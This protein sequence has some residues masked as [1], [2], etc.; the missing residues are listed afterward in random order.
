MPAIQAPEPLPREGQISSG[1]IRDDYVAYEGLGFCIYS[2]I[3]ADKIQEPK[4]RKLWVKAR[5]AMQEVVG[6]LERAPAPTGVRRDFF[7]KRKAAKKKIAKVEKREAMV[8]DTSD[9]GID[10]LGREV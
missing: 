7:T 9:F 4:L 6:Y 10:S 2:Y 8:E 5:Q 3:P 1:A